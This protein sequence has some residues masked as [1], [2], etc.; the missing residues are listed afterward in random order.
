MTKVK[1]LIEGY[2]DEEAGNASSSTT[3]ISDNG[4]YI[5]VDPGVNRELLLDALKN[6][7][8]STQDINYVIL[9]HTHLDHCALAGIFENAK[10]LDD[11]TIYSFNGNEEEHDGKVPG[12]DIQLISTP[13]HDQFHCFVLVDTKDY[14]KVA[15]G[16]DVFW[17][18]NEEEQKT[19]RESLLNHKDPYVKDEKALMESRKKVLE[20]ADYVIPGHGKMFK[21]EK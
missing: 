13:G 20:L 6:N 11:T 7:G 18:W 4:F 5:I 12:T 15:I 8:L 3:L 14:G 16:G 2:A 19:D 1:V 17:W 9:T 21:V 10:I